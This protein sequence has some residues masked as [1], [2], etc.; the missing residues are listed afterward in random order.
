MHGLSGLGPEGL[1]SG[2][3]AAPTGPEGSAR[4]VDSLA[5]RRWLRCRLLGLP[6]PK[7]RA[8][9]GSGALEGAQ[10]RL[11]E[12]FAVP[13]RRDASAFAPAAGC[14]CRLAAGPRVGG[15]PVADGCRSLG[16]SLRFGAPEGVRP[17]GSGPG[18]SVAA[19]RG[20]RRRPSSW[21]GARWVRRA[22]QGAR[23]RPSL[24]S[25]PVDPFAAGV[26][27]VG[28]LPRF[29][30]PEGAFPRGAGPGGSVA[31]AQGP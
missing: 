20:A 11:P 22:V 17:R 3:S 5:T 24:W 1:R 28:P 18:G 4:A 2:A 31:V 29:G 10:G 9:R 19:V 26:G 7:V 30:A 21:V 6:S 12:G 13:P 27:P 15:F 25:G 8:L 14:L 23:R 16:P